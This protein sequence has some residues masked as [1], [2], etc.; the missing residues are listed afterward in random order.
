VIEGLKADIPYAE[1]VAHMEA[2]R[3]HHLNRAAHYRNQFSIAS[4]KQM[5][6]GLD[7]NAAGSADKAAYFKVFADHLVTGE[8]YRLDRH[9][10]LA[11][12]MLNASDDFF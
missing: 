12:E 11:I 7:R 8:T 4:D 5:R 3:S 1:L 9:E 10:L 6:E 2:R